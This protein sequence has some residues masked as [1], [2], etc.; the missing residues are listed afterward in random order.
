MEQSIH[1]LIISTAKYFAPGSVTFDPP[2]VSSVSLG[3]SVTWG[4][5]L[6]NREHTWGS[7][8]GLQLRIW[9][10]DIISMDFE[11]GAVRAAGDEFPY[12]CLD[13][14]LSDEGYSNLGLIGH[15][16]AINGYRSF[17]QLLNRIPKN[18]QNYCIIIFSAKEAFLNTAGFGKVCQYHFLPIIDF[19]YAVK[20]LIGEAFTEKEVFY[21]DR[22]HLSDYGHLLLSKLV[23][24]WMKKVFLDMSWSE[25]PV[26]F[27][28]QQQVFVACNSTETV[29][30]DLALPE[31]HEGWT[32]LFVSNVRSKR[33]WSSATPGSHFT[34]NASRLGSPYNEFPVRKLSVGTIFSHVNSAAGGKMEIFFGSKL[35]STIDTCAPSSFP[36]TISRFWSVANK[37]YATDPFPSITFVVGKSERYRYTSVSIVALSYSYVKV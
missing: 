24:K 9:L 12:N 16:F 14:L 10:Q 2:H 29:N 3:G 25:K 21:K 6:S 18:V 28:G 27:P 31:P 37:D 8:V 22:H 20:P 34:F 7:L 5:G 15:E 30:R 4:A 17:H 36:H 32:E 1:S 35:M 19:E 26:T 23:L 11:N 13:A 33:V